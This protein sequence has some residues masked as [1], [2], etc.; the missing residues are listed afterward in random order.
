MEAL[1]S[2]EPES[3]HCCV[4]SPPYMGLRDYGVEPQVWG[5]DPLCVHDF[6][7]ETV[8]RQR[9]SGDG[10]EAL[11]ARYR[12]GGH[13]AASSQ[14]ITAERG[15]CRY[16]GAF[17]GSL[18]LEPT[19]GLYLDHMVEVMAAV[20]RVLRKDGCV[21]INVGDSFSGGGRTSFNA[22]IKHIGRG[23][24]FRTNG[25][26]KPKDLMLVPHRLAI[27]LQEWGWWVRS[28]IIWA[29]TAPMPESCNDRPTSAHEHVFLLT[30][31]AKYFWDSEAVKEPAVHGERYHG[32]YYKRHGCRERN[33]RDD[34]DNT[35]TSRNMRNV[36]HLG[37]S[38][39][40]GAHSATFHPEIPRRAILAG[41][42]EKGVCPN[43]GAQWVRVVKK[44]GGFGKSWH[45]HQDDLAIGQH[46]VKSAYKGDDLVAYKNYLVETIGWQ[47]SCQCVWNAP[48]AEVPNPIPATIL[49][50]FAGAFTTSLVAEQLQRDSIAIELSP[51]YCEMGRKRLAED[52]PLFYR[53]AAE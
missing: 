52:A 37:P 32:A 46:I 23:G 30:K 9:Y 34:E 21:F 51:K 19:L 33:G 10:L 35:T 43:C 22:D 39:F 29:K 24:S 42:S 31:S 50:P 16:C 3:V 27:R 1:A 41:T 5:G 15:R 2:L 45:D 7:T 36:W 17:F 47:P 4:T 53:E 49:D 14:E 28:D 26:L 8:M 18:G 13:K 11:G 12:G 20:W 48:G 38:R 44:S 25:G 40:P 6:A